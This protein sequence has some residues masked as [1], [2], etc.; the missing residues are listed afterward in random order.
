MKAEDQEKL[1]KLK[2]RKGS[3]G[4][5]IFMPEKDESDIE[6]QNKNHEELLIAIKELGLAM[7]VE[8][9]PPDIAPVIKELRVLQKLPDTFLDI[10]NMSL[11]VSNKMQR[12]LEYFN[13]TH[14][15]EFRVK[16]ISKLLEV[17]DH[18]N[19]TRDKK[20]IAKF[21]DLTT[22][23][24]Q[25]SETLKQGQDP[26]DFKPVRL[27]VGGDGVPLRFLNNMPSSRGGG[28]SSSSGG[29]D[30]SA[31]NQISGAQ[32]TQ[33]VDAGGEATTVTGGK[34]DV[35]AS[36]DTTGLATTTT[37]TNTTAISSGVGATGDAAATAGSTGSINAKLRLITSQIDAV[38]TAVE[39]LD[40]AISGSEMQVDV[41]GALPAGTNNIGDV[42]VLTLPG[43]AGD[44]ASGSADSGNPVKV[45]TKYNSALPT[46]TDGQRG[47]FQIDSKGVLLIRPYIG[48]VALV[49]VADNAD[50]VSTNSTASRQLIVNRNTV[51]DGSTWDR[52][53][54]NSTDGT[55]VN[56]GTNNDVSLNTGTNAIGK[57]LPP[58]VDVTTHTNYTKK[59]YTNAGAV[60]DGI[61]WSPASGKRWHVVSL[62]INTSAAATVTLEDDLAAGD[63][64]VMKMEL[65][66]NSGVAYNFTEKYPL[67][68]G[69]DAADLLVTTSAGN[70]YITCVGYE[71]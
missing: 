19:G 46:F 60:T 70:I 53:P 54:G 65:A 2:R 50:D 58:D 61:I 23:L 9:E 34:L 64:A 21:A 4:K 57:M 71:I 1:A 37:D 11:A 16:G 18:N 12:L 6:Q 32:K 66:A 25:L 3:E 45:G 43:V 29:G 10:K 49:A 27:V 13:N 17:I 51:F 30:A 67:A 44:V 14:K 20:L 28:G 63:S 33:I 31:S 5:I 47:E 62:I 35:N 22:Y 39:T 55:L 42:D 41:V 26:T 69:E 36:I 56:L 40:N 24:N 38:K 48:G 68:S 15:P 52:M 8:V 59:Y 7:K